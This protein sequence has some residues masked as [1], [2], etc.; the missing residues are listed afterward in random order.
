[1]RI[2]NKEDIEWRQAVAN[3]LFILF[4]LSTNETIKVKSL[5]R[6]YKQIWK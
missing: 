3:N 6:N 1:M 5:L 2:K 4:F